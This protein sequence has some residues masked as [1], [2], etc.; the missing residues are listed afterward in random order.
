MG[1]C[2]DSL[3]TPAVGCR[4]EYRVGGCHDSLTTPA[5]GCR[6]EYRVTGCH[7]SLLTPAVCCREEWGGGVMTYRRP[8]PHVAGRSMGGGVIT[9]C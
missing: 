2:H 3:T 4:E 7:D 9:H 8:L 6:E 5:I 1:G